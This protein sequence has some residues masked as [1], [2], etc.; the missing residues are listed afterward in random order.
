VAQFHWDPETYLELI[1][2]EVPDYEHLQEQAA[3]ATGTGAMRVLELGIG[4]GETARRVL[5][6]TR[7]QVL[8]DSTPAAR[9][10]TKPTTRSHTIASTCA[11]R[12]SRTPCPTAPSTW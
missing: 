5:H 2:E 4:T 7:P 6:A 11:S 10:S 12:A 9:C 1:R 8:S 3:V